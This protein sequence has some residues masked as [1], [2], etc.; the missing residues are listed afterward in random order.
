MLFISNPFYCI[1]LAETSVCEGTHHSDFGNFEPEPNAAVKWMVLAPWGEGFHLCN[2]WR[3]GHSDI[4]TD[5]APNQ[6]GL[7]SSDYW[8]ISSGPQRM[9]YL[10]WK[11][12]CL[13]QVGRRLSPRGKFEGTWGSLGAFD[14]RAA[15]PVTALTTFVKFKCFI[16]WTGKLNWKIASSRLA[17]QSICINWK[18]TLQHTCESGH[19]P[20]CIFTFIHSDPVPGF[21]LLCFW[22]AGGFR[23][24]VLEAKSHFSPSGSTPSRLAYCSR[25][26]L[27]YLQSSRICSVWPRALPHANGGNVSFTTGLGSELGPSL[28]RTYRTGLLSRIQFP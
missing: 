11:G 24:M 9:G 26:V 25:T 13:K 8:L 6:V 7:C 18:S 2:T 5:P 28:F 27:F 10:S 19:T 23:K 4:S 16:L 15:T 22:E 17:S 14:L 3:W 20:S 12:I 21:D 1:Q